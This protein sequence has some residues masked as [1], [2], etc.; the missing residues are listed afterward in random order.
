MGSTVLSP[1]TFTQFACEAVPVPRLKPIQTF[2]S[3]VPTIAWLDHF[4]EYLTWLMKE[5]LPS[6]CL[7]M[8][9]V[10]G[11]FV[12]YQLAAFMVA[13]PPA[14]VSQTRVVPATRWPQPPGMPAGAQS[15][16]PGTPPWKRSKGRMKDCVSPVQ[17]PRTV[18]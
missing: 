2:A 4:G 16:P 1:V 13:L 6:V 12:T 15:S 14:I 7:V 10:G 18:E 8:F 17:L 9:C 5:R 11:L 3:F